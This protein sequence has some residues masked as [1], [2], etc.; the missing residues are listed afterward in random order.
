MVQKQMLGGL[1]GD[2][3][4]GSRYMKKAPASGGRSLSGEPA[5]RVS[6][7]THL[8]VPAF[9]AVG[10]NWYSTSSDRLS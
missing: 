2:A 3:P 10:D 7:R 5:L 1:W 4:Y 6:Q 9:G 8:S